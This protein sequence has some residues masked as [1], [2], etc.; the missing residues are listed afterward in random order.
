MKTKAMFIGMWAGLL[1]M[2]SAGATGVS[3]NRFSFLPEPL[4]YSFEYRYPFFEAEIE[5][6]DW[7]FSFYDSEEE[8]LSESDLK[9]LDGYMGTSCFCNSSDCREIPKWLMHDRLLVRHSHH[10]M[11]MAW[12]LGF[13]PAVERALLSSQPDIKIETWMVDAADGWGGADVE[14][15]VADWML[16]DYLEKS[17]RLIEVEDWMLNSFFVE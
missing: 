10:E 13:E 7:M 6:E 9:W 8:S 4:F 5:L 17:D 14:I 1:F 12:M 15:E 2:L 3:Q 16:V 11:V